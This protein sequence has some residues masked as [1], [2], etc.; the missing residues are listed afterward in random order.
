M[1]RQGSI[2]KKCCNYKILLSKKIG[3]EKDVV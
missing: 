3:E 2:A 1:K